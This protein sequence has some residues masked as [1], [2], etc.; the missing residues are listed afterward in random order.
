MRRENLRCPGAGAMLAAALVAGCGGA[1][2]SDNLPVG[3]D[4]SGGT[5]GAFSGED[6][7]ASGA[8]DA[9][10]EENRVAVTFITLSC[11]G[12]CATVEAVGTGGNPPYSYA[13]DDGST[14][15]TRTVCPTSSTNYSVKVSER[16]APVSSRERRTARKCP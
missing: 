2:P 7:S 5:D 1:G 13:W 12:D 6:A 11:S 16:E 10:I 3:S 9:D 14:N 4:G 8:F 15:P